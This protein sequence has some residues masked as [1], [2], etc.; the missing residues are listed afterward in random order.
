VSTATDVLAIDLAPG[1][2]QGLYIRHPVLVASGGAG[3][4][5]ELL[6]AVGEEVP[7]AIVTRS[8]TLNARSGNPPPRMAATGSSLLNSIG[9]HNPGIEDALRR[10]APR[11][12]ASVVPI[13]VSICADSATD[14]ATLARTVDRQPGVAGIELNLA[15]PDSSRRGLPIGLDVSASEV[16]TVA[17]RAATDLP[18]IVKLTASVLDIREIAR[19]VA[20]A[21]ADAISAIDALPALAIDSDSGKPTLGTA[22]GGLSGPALKPVGLRAVYEIAQVVRVPIIGIGGIATL[23]DVLDYLAAGATAVGLATAALGSP[24]LPGRLGAALADWCSSS[25][26]THYREAIGTALPERR[27]RGSLRSG[28]YRP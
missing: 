6:N 10:Q 13:I 26:L 3:Y 19:A 7:G 27:D 4:G 8:T 2:G 15:C 22:Y 14:I 20:A 18:L 24:E 21:G 9:L 28:P 11:W 16:A 23:R 1:R 12:T 5:N 25:G 17:A